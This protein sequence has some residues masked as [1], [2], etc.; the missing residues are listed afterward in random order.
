MPTQVYQKWPDVEKDMHFSGTN[1][2]LFTFSPQ[3]P[4]YY[5]L[6]ILFISL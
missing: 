5:L 4:K 6:Y 3:C 1:N 2:T